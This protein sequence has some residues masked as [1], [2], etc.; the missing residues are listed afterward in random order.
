LKKGAEDTRTRWMK[1]QFLA[2]VIIIA[3]AFG[4]VAYYGISGNPDSL[5]SLIFPYAVGLLSLLIAI[6]LSVVGTII[7]RRR[8]K[9]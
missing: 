8:S 2:T 9:G 5:H 1:K 3:I 4:V 6:V 7:E